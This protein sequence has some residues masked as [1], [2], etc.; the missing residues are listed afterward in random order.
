V[1]AVTTTAVIDRL[2]IVAEADDCA[3][4]DKGA[5]AGLLAGRGLSLASEAIPLR[6]RRNET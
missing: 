3:V 5:A 6:G 1:A 2:R 4:A